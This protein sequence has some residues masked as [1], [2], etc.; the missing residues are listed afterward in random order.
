MTT[1]SKQFSFEIEP[2]RRHWRLGA[3]PANAANAYRSRFGRDGQAGQDLWSQ[4][5]QRSAGIDY[6]ALKDRVAGSP[7]VTSV[8][9]SGQ[10]TFV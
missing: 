2:V 7:K 6:Y 5:G 1:K 3:R 10:P 4:S 9:A 8:S